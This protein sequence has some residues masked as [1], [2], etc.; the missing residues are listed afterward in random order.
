[1]YVCLRS[2]KSRTELLNRRAIPIPLTLVIPITV[3]TDI[4]TQATKT[5]TVARRRGRRGIPHNAVITMT[6][7]TTV[8]NTR[9]VINLIMAMVMVTVMV[10]NMTA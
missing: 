4:S 8:T 6:T 3:A 5:I 7:M 9:P 2:S 1:M 10:T